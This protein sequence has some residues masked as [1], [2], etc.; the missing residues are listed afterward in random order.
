MLQ[1]YLYFM[2][3]TSRQRNAN[4]YQKGTKSYRNLTKKD[5]FCGLGIS[6]SASVVGC[7][8]KYDGKRSSVLGVFELKI[9]YPD[10]VAFFEPQVLKQ[11]YAS[12]L[13]DVIVQI[14]DGAAVVEIGGIEDL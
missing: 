8:E 6:I 12:L 5:R 10:G 4:N 1:Y 13:N 3:V 9:L 14:P 2:N 7:G 11:F